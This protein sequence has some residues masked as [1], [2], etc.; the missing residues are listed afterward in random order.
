M[1]LRSLALGLQCAA[2]LKLRPIDSLFSNPDSRSPSPAAGTARRKAKATQNR[3]IKAE[4][5]ELR[6]SIDSAFCPSPATLQQSFTGLVVAYIGAGT[7]DST[8]R[9]SAAR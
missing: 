5:R 9:D 8:V 6:R 4:T 3:T 2:E 1:A 7:N